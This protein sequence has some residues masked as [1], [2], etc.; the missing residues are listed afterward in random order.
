MSPQGL[1]VHA[2]LVLLLSLASAPGQQ[3]TAVDSKAQSPTAKWLAEQDP[4]WQATYTRDVVDFYTNGAAELK[5]QYLAG[6]EELLETAA[7]EGRLDDAVAI[8]GERDRVASGADAFAS[9]A[10]LTVAAMQNSRSAF[11]KNLAALAAE[12]TNRAKALHARY[13]AIL[14]QTQMALI[15]RS[16]TDE[17]VEIR[18]KRSQIVGQW[19]ETR[20]AVA[21]YVPRP[22]SSM[23]APPPST[24][25]STTPVASA[26]PSASPTASTAAA[27]PPAAEMDLYLAGS[28]GITV[29][30]NRVEVIKGVNREKSTKARVALRAGDVIAIRNGDRWDINSFWMSCISPNK[31][32]LFETTDRWTSFIPKDED[33]WWNLDNVREEKPAT[34]APDRQQ[35]VDR[36]KKAMKDTP[37]AHNAQPIRSVLKCAGRA[38]Y[39]HY[40]VTTQD[41]MPKPDPGAAGRGR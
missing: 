38:T 34:V 29:Y 24:A 16:R 40:T 6:L 4:Q 15:Q 5:N 1:I 32:F 8:R 37:F 2:L 28:N 26:P 17:A 20:P 10:A 3:A 39:L 18:T 41:L 14:E 27:A 25:P 19:I 36:V 13:D 11:A 21:A 22:A 33:K 23:V 35:Y 9:G 30:V 31:Q 7:R 12:R